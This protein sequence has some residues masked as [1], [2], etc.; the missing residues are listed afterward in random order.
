MAPRFVPA[1]FDGCDVGAERNP[2]LNPTGSIFLSFSKFLQRKFDICL[3]LN[4]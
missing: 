2:Y 4:F 1:H 3:G